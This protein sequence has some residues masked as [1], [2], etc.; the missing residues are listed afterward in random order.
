MKS[1]SLVEYLISGGLRVDPDGRQDRKSGP[2][3]VRKMTEEEMIKYNVQKGVND[4]KSLEIKVEDLMSI[5][6]EFGTGKEGCMKVAE[7]LNISEK[8][9][10]NQIYRK[11]IRRLLAEEGKKMVKMAVEQEKQEEKSKVLT[12]EKS[13]PVAEIVPEAKQLTPVEDELRPVKQRTR[14]KFKSLI[15]QDIEGF[16]YDF[17]QDELMI[18]TEKECLTIN[19]TDIEKLIAD[20][21]EIRQLCG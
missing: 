1:G 4:M 12:T 15:S 16:T 6:R 10:A 13:E 2:V 8:Q 19:Q 14:L 11:E 20:L 18:C 5:C 7:K 3:T 17:I 9:A 21:Q